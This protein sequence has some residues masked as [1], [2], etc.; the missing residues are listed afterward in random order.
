MLKTTGLATLFPF[1]MSLA[2]CCPSANATAT[3]VSRPQRSFS[4][5]IMQHATLPPAARLTTQPPAAPEAAARPEI[6]G[7]VDRAAFYVVDE[8]P[9]AV[10]SYIA[11]H[12]AGQVKVDATATNEKGGTVETSVITS[13]QVGGPNERAA[14]LIYG[15][16]PVAN[17]SVIRVDAQTSWV[18]NRSPSESAPSAAGGTLVVPSAPEANPITIKLGRRQS[19]LLKNVINSLPLAARAYCAEAQPSYRLT[20]LPASK[21]TSPFEVTGYNCGD[22]VLVKTQGRELPPLDDEDGRLMDTLRHLFPEELAQRNSNGGWA[23]WVDTNP[24]PGSNP[25]FPKDWTEVQG[26]WTAPK[27]NCDFLEQA[28]SVQWVG[29][30]GWN[31]P[32]VE[33]TGTR[34]S[35]VIGQDTY[36]VWWEMFGDNAINK[37][38][39]V[40]LPGSDHVHPGDQM[41]AS[42]NAILVSGSRAYFLSLADLTEG[43]T[44]RVTVD[45]PVSPQPLDGT[46][47]WI[48][49]QPSC[50]WE[51]QAL[52]NFGSVT[53]SRMA[54]A[55]GGPGVF[56]VPP[57]ILASGFDVKLVTGTTVKATAGPLMDAPAAPICSLNLPCLNFSWSESMTVMFHH[58]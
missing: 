18:P 5:Q 42:V 11:S 52:A 7:L 17:A 38:N 2:C 50:F 30:D 51:C 23:G 45:P 22:T 44:F 55:S 21:L 26:Q 41:F 58:K 25:A 19:N 1:M 48:V 37:G 16:T 6:S 27:A 32:T 14:F 56:A 29:I 15:I 10:A 53:F 47:E 31:E 54:L 35:C 12:S 34:A 24:L 46:A 33:Q 36:G 9:A 28:A 4:K 13:L 49:E 43:W 40:D 39:M 57:G 20:L 8:P 3:F